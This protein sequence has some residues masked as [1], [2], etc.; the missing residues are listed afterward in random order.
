MIFKNSYIYT[1]INL[2][3][4]EEL[5]NIDNYQAKWLINTNKAKSAV[6]LFHQN[7]NTINGQPL[8]RVNGEYIPYK[9]TI[10]ILGVELDT[11]LNMKKHIDKRIRM[12]KHT[13]NR[14]RRFQILN[15]KIQLQL[16]MTLSLAQALYSPTAFIFPEKYGINK[17]QKLQNKAIRQVYCIRWNE[18]IKN[19]DLHQQHNI[20]PI[21]ETLY[22]RFTRAF[23]KFTDKNY[24]AYQTIKQNQTRDN[25]FTI[26]MANPPESSI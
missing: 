13:L 16:F 19:K 15:T 14:L 10:K 7:Q 3:I 1:E 20:D 11:K 8:I 23:Q 6:T 17:T 26:L 22:T 21:S 2:A 12:E 4:Q 25:R 18:F 5:T 24:I 9:N